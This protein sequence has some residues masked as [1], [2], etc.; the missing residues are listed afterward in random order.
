[1]MLAVRRCA[2]RS[3]VHHETKKTEYGKQFAGGKKVT[4]VPDK[5]SEHI[6]AEFFHRQKRVWVTFHYYVSS[7]QNFDGTAG[8]E[9]KKN[10]ATLPENPQIFWENATKAPVLDAQTLFKTEMVWA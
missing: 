7:I 8:W 1:M 6:T 4:M 10:S 3:A 2:F 9:K 5:N